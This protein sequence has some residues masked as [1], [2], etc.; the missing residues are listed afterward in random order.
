MKYRDL[1]LSAG[2]SALLLTPAAVVADNHDD[3]D[4]EIEFDEAHVCFERQCA[5]SITSPGSDR[6]L[7]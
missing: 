2:L 3:D 6:D 4:D 5:R 7:F 1:Y